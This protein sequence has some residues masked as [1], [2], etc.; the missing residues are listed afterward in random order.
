MS[1]LNISIKSKKVKQLVNINLL[2][3]FIISSIGLILLW[4]YNTY[5]ISRYLFEASIIVYR[6]G[7]LIGVFSIIYGIFFENYLRM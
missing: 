4:V 2:F 1:N 5:Y 6:T 3:S 7:L